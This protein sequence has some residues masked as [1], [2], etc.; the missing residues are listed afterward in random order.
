MDAFGGVAD[1]VHADADAVAARAEHPGSGPVARPG[2]GTE[3]LQRVGQRLHAR[4][5][6]A[7]A[8]PHRGPDST[9]TTPVVLAEQPGDAWASRAGRGLP[10]DAE[11]VTHT[12]NA[13]TL[14]ISLAIGVAPRELSAY[15]PALT[16]CTFPP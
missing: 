13:Y 1:A 4:A 10:E 14:D 15:R 3:R 7:D 12:E 11:T 16:P 8:A 9:D 5:H 2:A 6:D